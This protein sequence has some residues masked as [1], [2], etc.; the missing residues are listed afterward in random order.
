MNRAI[1]EGIASFGRRIGVSIIGSVHEIIACGESF[2]LSD[3]S[4]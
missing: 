2:F 4:V 3:R 1:R